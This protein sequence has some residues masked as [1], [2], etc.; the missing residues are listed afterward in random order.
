MQVEHGRHVDVP[1][2]LPG[3]KA[4]VYGLLGL[5]AILLALVTSRHAM[6]GDEAQAW[7]IARDSGNLLE[8]AH[9]LRYEGHPALWYLLIYLPAHLSASLVWMSCPLQWPGWCSQ[10]VGCP[11]PCG[12]WPSSACSSSSTWD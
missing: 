7:L 11:L 9:H 1:M 12:S 6:F 5:F 10:N 2:E 4:I 8:L 3:E